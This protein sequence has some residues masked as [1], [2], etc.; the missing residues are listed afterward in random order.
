MPKR[1]PQQLIIPVGDRPEL[2]RRINELAA[3]DGR[4]RNGWLLNQLEALTTVLLEQRLQAVE[5]RA[6]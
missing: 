2:V 4:T 1:I 5:E 3:A 6:A